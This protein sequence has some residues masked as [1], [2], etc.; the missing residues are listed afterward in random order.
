MSKNIYIHY[1]HV[2]FNEN[3]FADIKNCDFVK[4]H[5]GLWASNVNAKYGWKDW[6]KDNNFRDCL[7]E[8]SFTFKLKD[9]AKVLII[10]DATKLKK[11]PTIESIY[12]FS[13]INL[14]FEKIKQEYDA[15]EVLI[16][17]DMQLYWDLYGWDCDSLLVM[18]KDI[19]EII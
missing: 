18:N 8:N 9:N 3:L 4:P 13:W 11:L 15:I 7:E 12:K 14:D 1:G 2:K 16:S 6:C 19:I 5:G 17:E 10:D